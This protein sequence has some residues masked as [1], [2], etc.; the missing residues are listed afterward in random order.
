[1]SYLRYL[2]LFTHSGVQHVWCCISVLFF[3]AMCT[4]CCQFYGLSILSVPS[5]FSNVYVSCVLCTLCCQFS[6]LFILIVPSILSHVY[7]I[8][9]VFVLHLSVFDYEYKK[10]IRKFR[11]HKALTSQ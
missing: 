5:V 6:G 2:C 4:R 1:M 8:R 10:L 9:T 11:D 7:Q 3:F